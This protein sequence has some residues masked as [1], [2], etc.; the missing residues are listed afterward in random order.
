MNDKIKVLSYNTC[1]Q[2]TSPNG[3]D[4][5][6]L[7][8]ICH[9]NVKLCSKNI[10]N[11]FNNNSQFDFIALQEVVFKD[12]KP[13]YDKNM[14]LY[15]YIS[16][17]VLDN[18]EFVVNPLNTNR[19]VTFYNK[20]FNLLKLLN[21]KVKKNRPFQILVFSNNLIFINIHAP[22][23]EVSTKEIEIAIKNKFKSVFK[24]KRLMNYIYRSDIIIAGDFNRE[25]NL[26]HPFTLFN[27]NFL[28]SKKKVKSCCSKSEKFNYKY[29]SDLVMT[30]FTK[31]FY[32]KYILPE[33]PASDHLPV[34]YNINY[35]H[36]VTT[37]QA[38]TTKHSGK[39]K[40]SKISLKSKNK[41]TS[42][43][44]NKFK[45]R[46]SQLDKDIIRKLIEINLVFKHFK[47]LHELIISTT[48]D[49]NETFKC[50]KSLLN[51]IDIKQ[52][53]GVDEIKKLKEIQKNI[54]QEYQKNGRIDD[55][56]GMMDK[57]LDEIN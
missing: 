50:L 26:S 11:V 30:N 41:I 56:I 5:G 3:K 18:M 17:H 38:V 10:G 16:K 12:N 9:E 55:S 39:N 44:F 48:S 25:F 7:G 13:L 2:T 46:C 6:P 35:K 31:P 52:T 23:K 27:K 43:S 53:I 8:K 54:M 15:P 45:N 57:Y 22:H 36:A 33:Y 20:R 42:Y 37:K 47:S 32:Y 21:G 28:Y 51:T 24:T 40:H 4:F 19:I 1:W 49:K 14:V 29:T 34:I